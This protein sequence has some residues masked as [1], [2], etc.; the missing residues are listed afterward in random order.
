MKVIITKTQQNKLVQEGLIDVLKQALVQASKSPE[1]KKLIKKAMTNVLKKGVSELEK[2]TRGPEDYIEALGK[3]PAEEPVRKGKQPPQ[4]EKEV[5]VEVEVDVD[6]SPEVTAKKAEIKRN[7]D[8][9]EELK[10]KKKKTAHD[11][12]IIPMIEIN[13][14]KLK[15]EL[16]K[17]EDKG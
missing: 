3:K 6:E 1:V 4:K 16:R 5:E 9:L 17:L 13:V 8:I 15:M 7:E 10:S 2:F 12:S 14:T 11:R